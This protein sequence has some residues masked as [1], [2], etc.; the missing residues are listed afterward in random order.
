MDVLSRPATAAA[1]ALASGIA[2][3]AVAQLSFT[4]T[5]AILGGAVLALAFAL[6]M[7]SNQRISSLAA[8]ICL[9]F[10]LGFIR[11]SERFEAAAKLS[12]YAA[13]A[14]SLHGIARDVSVSDFGARFLL[15]SPQGNIQITLRGRAAAVHGNVLRDGMRAT[16]VGPVETVVRKRNP[17]DFDYERFLFSRSVW[18]AATL[19]DPNRL[20]VFE[21]DPSLIR[22]GIGRAQRYVADV[23][24]RRAATEV[25]PVIHALLLG[26]RSYLDDE[27][28]RTLSRTGLM[29]LLAVSGLHVV[30]V[31]LTI[32]R[33]LFSMLV[34]MR[35][36]WRAMEAVRT[37]TTVLLLVAYAALTG[38]SPSVVRAVLMA[39]L[40]ISGSALRRRADTLNSLGVAA[41]LLL[42]ARPE[43]LFSVGFQL[44]FCA[45]GA[46]VS[47]G[48]S[49][50]QTL[51]RREPAG[52]F[53]RSL[54][55]SIA[56]TAGTAPVLLVTFGYV[57]L[58]G[59]ILNIAAI[60]LASLTLA[61]GFLMAIVD[62]AAPDLAI[63]LQLT[64]SHSAELLLS[65]AKF[66]DT[67]L[68]ATVVTFPTNTSARILLAAS[69]TI[70]TAH[71]A[72]L[73]AR[74]RLTVFC[75]LAIV[76]SLHLH[77]AR[78]GNQPLDI[79]F[80]DVGQ[81]DAA[82]IRTPDAHFIVVD[83]GPPGRTMTAA[84]RTVI[85]QLRLMRAKA[86][87]LLLVTHAHADHDGGVK[88]LV[89][90]FE[91]KNFFSSAEDQRYAP[92]SHRPLFA[93]QT[94]RV[95]KH[96]TL[97]VLNPSRQ[98]SALSGA[99]R[100]VNNNSIAV[101]LDFGNSCAL[102]TGDIE[103]EA[104]AEILSSSQNLQCDIVKVAHHGS[105]TSSSWAFWKATNHPDTNKD[106]DF[107]IISVGRNN[108][109]GLPDEEIVDRWRRT[110]TVFQ[111]IEGAV[112]L[113]SDGE[114]I[115]LHEWRKDAR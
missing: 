50:A 47:L 77:S 57:P 20:R 35:I 51:A 19:R 90:A 61:A 11:A 64:V 97:S 101:R 4:F 53:S 82:V 8:A 56:A 49:I 45:V 83:T 7:R 96:V 31:G 85:P 63:L 110:R 24:R 80:L 106:Q 113:K 114:H 78:A 84:E 95:G 103:Q 109:F 72:Q 104:E 73:S 71:L 16:F 33:I 32:H 58:A 12:A 44:S 13:T 112:W 21:A 107:A 111:T 62:V 18:G 59:I 42:L 25:H 89:S 43:R 86:I 41:F 100:S 79:V 40:I 23:V 36:P 55:T 91:T 9:L 5:T 14:T 92:A 68:D 34:R 99:V 70:I 39:T 10:A 65:V 60:P 88:D 108:R 46:I 98:P 81:G 87:D 1:A 38:N 3:R 115:Y 54:A 26:D 30:L 93:G 75:M 76:T 2:I 27:L 37:P 102:L 105:R 52:F 28:Q 22:R 67:Y 66:A 69:V 48:P 74:W 94:L 6:L 15:A 17:G 29:H